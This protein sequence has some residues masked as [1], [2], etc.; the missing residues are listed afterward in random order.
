[1]VMIIYIFPYIIV[2]IFG[3]IALFASIG[4]IF[5]AA[6][7]E[8]FQWK[9]MVFLCTWSLD[10]FEILQILS[11]NNKK[12]QKKGIFT[13]TSIHISVLKYP[14]TGII[15]I[16]VTVDYA[17][18]NKHFFTAF[19][20]ADEGYDVWI[21]NFR[22]NEYSRNHTKLNPDTDSTFWNFTFHEMGVYDLSTTIDYILKLTNSS[23]LFYV[24][25]SQ[26]AT[27]MYALISILPQFN[28][29]IKVYVHMA[30]IAFMSQVK[31]PIVRILG[32][33]VNFFKVRIF[34]RLSLDNKY[35]LYSRFYNN[36]KNIKFIQ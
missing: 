34:K 27:A 7:G 31:S 17:V 23:S 22:G 3:N 12:K 13:L 2:K 9:T 14:I 10:A 21:G 30:P 33:F 5:L 32:Y 6:E 16:A 24:G 8:S 1:M 26:G 35:T 28:S 25:I 11:Q 15:I 18:S 4:N 29:K 20:L 36:V 19:K